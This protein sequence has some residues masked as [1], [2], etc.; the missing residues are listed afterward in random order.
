[1]VECEQPVTTASA[2][3]ATADPPVGSTNYIYGWG[4]IYRSWIRSVAG[5]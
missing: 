2:P 3:L 5:V 4:T 1:V